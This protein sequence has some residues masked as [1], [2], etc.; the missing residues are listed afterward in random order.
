MPFC[1]ECGTKLTDT[2]KFC[3]E[4]GTKTAV[5]SA[6]PSPAAPAADSA[7]PVYAE[8]VVT[9]RPHGYQKA[10]W[11][12][13]SEEDRLKKEEERLTFSVRHAEAKT[14]RRDPPKPLADNHWYVK[15]VGL[16][17]EPGKPV[18]LAIDGTQVFKS[19][20]DGN[21]ATAHAVAKAHPGMSEFELAIPA[22]EFEMR[23]QYDAGSGNYLRFAFT[24]QGLSVS[25]QAKP[26]HES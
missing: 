11:V 6:V 10:T 16:P 4:C 18:T 13:E 5:G 17:T 20:D 23:Q 15:L 1:T 26:F 24:E 9:Q 2:A 25:H 22:M 7:G 12:A 14:V 19:K 3:T 21:D 8:A